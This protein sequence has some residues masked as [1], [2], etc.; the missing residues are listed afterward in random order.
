M[1]LILLAATAVFPQW[2]AASITAL[3]FAPSMHTSKSNLS[4]SSGVS[5]RDKE[6]MSIPRLEAAALM[7]LS[8]LSPS[9]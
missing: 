9:W 4:T 7:R 1:S 8:A 3:L 2:S 5:A 6:V